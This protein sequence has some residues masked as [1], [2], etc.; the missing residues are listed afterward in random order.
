MRRGKGNRTL[1]DRTTLERLYWFEEMSCEEIGARYG[2]NGASVCQ[3]LHTEGIKTRGRGVR[4]Y[5]H[6]E[7]VVCGEPVCRLKSMTVYGGARWHISRFCAVHAAEHI[8][9]QCRERMRKCRGYKTKRGPYR[10]PELPK[11]I[12]R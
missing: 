8:R 9:A 10:M 7:C 6:E 4:R 1:P 5:H 3:M 12:E 11:N 2:V